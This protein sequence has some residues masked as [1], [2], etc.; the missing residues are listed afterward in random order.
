MK[1]VLKYVNATWVE[2][3]RKIER[4]KNVIESERLSNAIEVKIFFNKKICVD[5]ADSN[6]KAELVKLCT[7]MGA[8]IM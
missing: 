7:S 6:K 1:D 5:I 3:Q 4:K 2:D 8:K